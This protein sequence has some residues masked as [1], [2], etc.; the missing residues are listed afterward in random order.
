MF[1]KLREVQTANLG[2][3][4]FKFFVLNGTDGEMFDKLMKNFGEN[5][6]EN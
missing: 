6:K 2:W 4:S 5:S 1:E 3:V